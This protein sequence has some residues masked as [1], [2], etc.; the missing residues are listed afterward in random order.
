MSRKTFPAISV[1]LSILPDIPVRVRAPPSY[2]PV[3]RG[4]GG[5]D[6]QP[7]RRGETGTSNRTAA[8]PR[9][10]IRP[11]PTAAGSAIGTPPFPFPHR[12]IATAATPKGRDHA[13][14]HVTALPSNLDANYRRHG[15]RCSHFVRR[16]VIAGRGSSRG[17]PAWGLS[18]GTRALNCVHG[19]TG[20]SGDRRLNRGP[21]RCLT[22]VLRKPGVF[23]ADPAGPPRTPDVRVR[24]C[25]NPHAS[26]SPQRVE[27]RHL[28]GVDA[29]GG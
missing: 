2:V 26:F 22:Q 27:A 10:A 13:V 19:R 28:A 23:G 9:P 20:V 24:V 3:G 11:L 12:A 25:A 4:R 1:G 7:E 8:G 17:S 16:P 18:P 6:G 29:A 5:Q 21:A 15:C 14:G